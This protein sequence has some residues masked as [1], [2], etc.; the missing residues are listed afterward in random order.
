[1][2]SLTQWTWVWASSG[3]WWW[4]WKPGMLQSMGSQRVGHNWATKLTDWDQECLRALTMGRMGLCP[5]SWGGCREASSGMGWPGGFLKFPRPCFS[6]T[7]YRGCLEYKAFCPHYL[8]ISL[9]RPSMKDYI[10]DETSFLPAKMACVYTWEIVF[11]DWE[12][13]K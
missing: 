10:N 11:L 3:S 1:M 7:L 13:R 9:G 2:A 5:Q 8:I 12:R 4:T 6:P